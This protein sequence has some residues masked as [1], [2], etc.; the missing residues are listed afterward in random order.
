MAE[1]LAAFHAD[2]GETLTVNGQQV[3][4]EQALLRS[5]VI[6]KLAFVRLVGGRRR[7]GGSDGRG[8]FLFPVMVLK[9]MR[10]QCRLLVELFSAGIAFKGGFVTERVNLH[11]V[12]E[13][14]FFVGGEVAVS[15]LVLFAS[16][17]FLMV[18]ASVPLQ[19]AAG[20][21]FLT[22][23]HAGVDGER[24]SIWTNDD[25]CRKTNQRLNTNLNTANETLLKL[26]YL[27]KLNKMSLIQ[28][29]HILKY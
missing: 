20:F 6:A 14:G 17:D 24:L 26:I 4:I 25:C 27:I 2:V 21:E 22:A 9:T 29:K 28:H 23:Q 12:V 19:K 15:A 16:Q 18:V 8:C 10:E 11:V 1:T 13:A 7:E 3:A 5:L